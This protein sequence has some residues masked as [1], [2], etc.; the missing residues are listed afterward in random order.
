MKGFEI[1]AL[2]KGVTYSE[3]GKNLGI[4]RQAVSLWGKDRNIPTERLEALSEM[5]ECS[6]EYLTA[7]VDIESLRNDI[8]KYL[9]L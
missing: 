9:N 3:I 4:S 8:H 6:V 5:L 7:E 1:I 2:M